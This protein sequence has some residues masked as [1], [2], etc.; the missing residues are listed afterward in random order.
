MP[1]QPQPGGPDSAT[2]PSPP[3]HALWRPGVGMSV[4]V[5]GDPAELAEP[6]REVLGN[7]RFRSEIPVIGEGDRRRFVR[8]HPGH[9][10]GGRVAGRLADGRGRW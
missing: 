6:L 10:H 3:L 2:T 1:S 9:H 4:W 5:D 7:R 8:G